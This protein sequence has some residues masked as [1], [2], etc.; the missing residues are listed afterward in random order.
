MI[1][2]KLHK[3]QPH[4]CFNCEYRSTHTI[5]LQAHI[6]AAH[7][8]SPSVVCEV[9]DERFFELGAMTVSICSTFL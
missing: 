4:N 8:K 5:N 1:H 9:C 7:P 2:L 6:L 3:L